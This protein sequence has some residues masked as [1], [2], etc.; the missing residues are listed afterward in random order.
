[1]H[2]EGRTPAGCEADS[3]A[4]AGSVTGRDRR[5][6]C[7]AGAPDSEVSRAK[8][9]SQVV[10]PDPDSSARTAT[11]RDVGARRLDRRGRR[12]RPGAERCGARSET[13]AQQD[14]GA[15][16][17][18]RR[19]DCE[20]SDGRGRR[21]SR[22]PPVLATRR[23]CNSDS[24]TLVAPTSVNGTARPGEPSRFSHAMR[25]R[26]RASASCTASRCTGSGSTERPLASSR[27]SGCCR[28]PPTCTRCSP[29]ATAPSIDGQR[30][31]ELWTELKAASPDPV[32][33][34]DGRMVMAG[35]LADRGKLEEAIAVLEQGVEP[36]RGRR[37]LT[38]SSSGTPSPT[39][40]SER[41]T[42]RAPGRSSN[43]SGRW[44]RRSPTW[45]SGCAPSAE[46]RAQPLALNLPPRSYARHHF[47]FRCIH[48]GNPMNIVI[49][50]GV[51]SREPEVRELP[52]GDHVATFDVTVRDEGLE[53]D[54]VPVS[55]LGASAAALDKLDG[56]RRR[57]R[58]R[59][60]A[61]P[62]VPRWGS[63]AEPHRGAGHRGRSCAPSAEGPTGG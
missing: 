13:G 57:R 45:G 21:S 19:A 26:L 50:H 3:S 11:A 41:A 20:P 51:L 23:S 22:P 2:R 4:E 25:R 10:A 37:S 14:R 63:D 40:T 28:A 54:V 59:S 33:M 39:S 35:A 16:R 1:M 15:R 12:T 8:G 53:T 34:A 17:R 48:E 30:S 58:H 46:S 18:G 7:G 44:I 38:T 9:A 27:P 31:E 32:V 6:E 43:G 42:S 62:L 5:V 47:P 29:T 55:W 61:T 24:R 49:L 60:G 56:R 36:S 52:S